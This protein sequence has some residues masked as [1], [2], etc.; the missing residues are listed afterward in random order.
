MRL[1]VLLALLFLVSCNENEQGPQLSFEEQLA[2]DVQTIDDYLE[3]KG[4]TNVVR[5]S[6]G[7]R[8]VIHQLGTGPLPTPDSFLK[9]DY[10]GRL[11]ATGALF[12]ESKSPPAFFHI[13]VRA[14]IYGFQ[15]SCGFLPRGSKATLYIPSGLAYGQYTYGVIPS[16]ANVVFDVDIIAIKP[17]SVVDVQN[18][19]YVMASSG[20]QV[21]LD[22]NLQSSQY[23]NLDVVQEFN[24]SGDSEYGLLYS[25]EVANDPRGL[26]PAGFHIPSQTE[27][28]NLDTELT[29]ENAGFRDE[30]GSLTGFTEESVHWSSTA[31]EGTNTAMAY[32]VKNSVATIKPID[33]RIKASV[34]CILD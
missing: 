17:S 28:E 32:V 11:L 10:E 5:D 27:W 2:L 21:W 14:L 24:Y 8:Y 30:N 26:C 23:R 25:F 16:N 15:R 33:K 4:I 13:P 22:R 1:R 18:N 19:G 34:R 6:S 7:L 3:S 20:Y 12:D 31:V 9:A 29:F